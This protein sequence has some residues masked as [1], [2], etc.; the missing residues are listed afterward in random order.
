[1]KLLLD[2]K[3]GAVL[4]DGKPVYVHD[5]G[6]EIVFDGAQ[7][8]AKIGQLT[9][10]NTDYKRRFTEAEGKIKAFEGLDDPEAARTALE[11]V[12]NLDV[13]QLKTAAQV[14]EIKEAAARTAQEQVAA[15]AKASATREQELA[16]QLEKRTGELNAHM[17]GGG[18]ASSKLLTDD[19]HPSR[20][21]IPPEM[22]KAYFG[23]NF[24]VEDGKMVPYDASGNKIYS[25]NRPGEVA[26]FDEGLE[27]LVR[28]CPFKDQIIKA[29]G[30]SGGGAQPGGGS[31]GKKQIPRAQFEQLAPQERASYIKDG[32]TVA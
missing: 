20:L 13:G 19:K 9:G 18:F 25:P 14:A 23:S 21:V 8:F 22:A 30:A 31:A 26:D 11:T 3:G 7:A 29:S 32:G 5:D 27:A 15:A 6:R 17:I 28:A 12:R 2:D 10:E 4:R 16:A 24:K 1:M